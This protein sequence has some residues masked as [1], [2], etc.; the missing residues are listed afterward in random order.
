MIQSDAGLAANT[1]FPT[2]AKLASRDPHSPS[3]SN[4]S[5]A[6]MNDARDVEAVLGPIEVKNMTPWL[7]MK[8]RKYFPDSGDDAKNYAARIELFRV[9]GKVDALRD[10]A[11]RA[12]WCARSSNGTTCRPRRTSTS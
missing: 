5:P 11:A 1:L 7:T 12:R 4:P 9:E 6:I 10:E 3:A 2:S 8:L